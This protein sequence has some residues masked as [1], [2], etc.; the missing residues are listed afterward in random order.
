MFGF[1]KFENYYFGNITRMEPRHLEWEEL[2][3]D[4]YSYPTLL[5]KLNNEKYI[6]LFHENRE[7]LIT[8]NNV[9]TCYVLNYV[10]PVGNYFPQYMLINRKNFT[11]EQAIKYFGDS[12]IEFDRKNSNKNVK[13]LVKNK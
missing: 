11:K 2:Y 4:N 6:D 3:N 10:E 7:I 13:K 8:R 5:L 9:K 1:Y 12:L